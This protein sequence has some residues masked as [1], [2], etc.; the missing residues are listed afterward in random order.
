MLN[1]YDRKTIESIFLLL[2]SGFNRGL[3]NVDGSL[4]YQKMHVVFLED[5]DEG[6]QDRI[7][8]S[9]KIEEY[10]PELIIKNK[11]E[12]FNKL[13]EFATVVKNKVSRFTRISPNL[14]DNSREFE[15]NKV[16]GLMYMIWFNATP[17]D[18]AD[19]VSFLDRYIKFIKDGTFSKLN[20]GF[21]LGGIDLKNIRAA[22]NVKNL[23]QRSDME[24]PNCLEFYITGNDKE[25][26]VLPRV[27][28]GIS[29]TEHGEKI[30]YIYAIQADKSSSNRDS[31]LYKEFNRIIHGLRKRRYGAGSS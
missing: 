13:F 7:Q 2:V 12:F 30:G 27:S 15:V 8:S 9:D 4:Q 31:I 17:Q 6:I 19:P 1:K 29:K 23:S 28:Y 14:E 5:E 21:T 16:I 11:D 3:V 22:V 20:S 26:Y 25:R 10:V 18:F 24:T